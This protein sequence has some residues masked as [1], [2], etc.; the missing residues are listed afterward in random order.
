[1]KRR[2]RGAVTNPT[3]RFERYQYVPIEERDRIETT[4]TPDSTRT[5]IASNDSPD[6]PFDFSINPYRGCEH[7]CIYCFARPTHAFLGLSP[8]LDFETRIFSKPKAAE[9]LR[10]ELSKPG[11]V[12]HPLALGANTDPYQPV[13]R[14]LRIPRSIV[15]VLA[16]HDHPLSIVTKS[17]LVLRDVD[18]LAPMA[19]KNLASVFVSI[20]TLDPDL[21]RRMEPRASTPEKRLETLRGLSQ[22]GIPCGV[23]A[24]PMIPA[25]NDSELERILKEGSEAG[26]TTAG[27]VL[28]RLP[29]E[30]KDLFSEWLQ[31]HYPAKAKH[32]EALVRETRGGGLYQSEFGTRMR[33]TGPY[34]ELLEKRFRAAV[35]KFDLNRPRPALD[36]SLFRRTSLPGAQM[37]LFE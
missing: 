32:V 33:G 20:T 9:L 25:L 11:Y 4:V 36:T 14:D 30:L 8:G 12:C 17:Q 37:R 6:V 27:Y 21:A 31:T 16:E 23:L 10:K 26:A 29:L 28:L 35:K 3:G 22:E 15:E 19:K 1:M 18:L 7:G 2:G 5:I 24:S 13:E 34:A